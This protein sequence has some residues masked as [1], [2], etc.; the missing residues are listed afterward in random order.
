MTLFFPLS[1]YELSL[2]NAVCFCLTVEFKSNV[3]LSGIPFVLE[4]NSSIWLREGHLV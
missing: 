2:E 1:V 3:L 4:L